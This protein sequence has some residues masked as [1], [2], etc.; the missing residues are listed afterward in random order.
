MV[1]VRYAEVL[2][3]SLQYYSDTML[4]GRKRADVQLITTF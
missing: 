4:N 1:C 2:V 3:H